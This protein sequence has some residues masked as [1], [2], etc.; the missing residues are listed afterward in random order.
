MKNTKRL[1]QKDIWTPMFIMALFTTAKIGGKAQVTINRWTDKDDA[2]YIQWSTCCS[3]FKLCLI[4]H[5]SMNCST[6]G[7]SVRHY[8][9]FLKLMSIESVMPSNHLILLSPPSPLALNFTEH[10]GLF[11]WVSSL[12]QVAKVLELQLQH[13]PFQWIFRSAFL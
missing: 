1:I 8:L 11:Q 12:Y 6:S 3:V 7:F 9:C 2:V 13:Q 4:P 5:D 10:Q